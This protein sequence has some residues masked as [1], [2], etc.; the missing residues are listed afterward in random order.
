MK[1]LT[2]DDLRRMNLGERYWGARLDRVP[3]CDDEGQ[4]YQHT[5]LALRYILKAE[6]VMGKGVGILWWGLNGVGKT[7]IMS[8]VAKEIARRGYST[9]LVSSDDLK[10]AHMPNG[11]R[12]I[13]EGED[14]SERA[15]RVEWL[16]IDDLGKE[17]RSSSGFAENVVEGLFR[18]RCR[19]KKATCVTSN[20]SPEEIKTLF[21]PS[22]DSMI[23]EMMIRVQ[24]RGADM[25]KGRLKTVLEELM[26]DGDA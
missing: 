1:T 20:A 22:F 15:R 5:R 18:S 11:D 26:R 2:E 8:A 17:W 24:V 4:E 12:F 23:Q 6:F 16:G 3:L 14:L 19:A 21:G 13:I 10:S 25:R 9:L 7:Y